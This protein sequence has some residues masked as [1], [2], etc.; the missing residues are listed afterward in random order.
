MK[1]FSKIVNGGKV[2]QTLLYFIQKQPPEVL[3]KKKMF[4]K[5]SY[6]QSSQE[7]ICASVCFLIKLQAW[8]VIISSFGQKNG[9]KLQS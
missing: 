9:I 1:L 5:I 4:L 7:N 3:Y 6:Y 2:L 8:G